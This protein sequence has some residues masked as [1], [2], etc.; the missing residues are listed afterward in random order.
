MAAMLELVMPVSLMFNPELVLVS[1]G[2][3]AAVNDPLGGMMLDV[4]KAD[5][6][7]VVGYLPIFVESISFSHF[8]NPYRQQF[9]SNFAMDDEVV[10]ETFS[11]TIRLL[12][13]FANCL[14]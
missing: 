8:F 9:I 10:V 1:A 12:I 3:D 2:F 6:N 11:M 14:L 13:P 5:I 4:K 7:I